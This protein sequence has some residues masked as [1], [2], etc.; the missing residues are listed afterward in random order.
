MKKGK[1]FLRVARESF[2]R[3]SLLRPDITGVKDMIL[4]L[5]IEMND[6]SAAELHARQVLRTNR[7]HALANYVMGSLRLQEGEYGEAEDFLRRSVEA[8]PSSAALNDL[9]EVLRRI[10]KLDDAERFARESIKRNPDLYV[11]WETLG[12][13]LLEANR[14]LEEAESAVNKALSLYKEDFRIKITLA[15]I[16]HRRGNLEKARETLS[17]VKMHKDGL[18]KFDLE[19]MNQL[20]A[21]I[22]KPRAK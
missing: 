19:V 18:T 10:R 2:I 11:A 14:N 13:V 1:N 5:D 15:R 12:C 4:Q 21:E 17:E 3:A 22:S 6:Q 20:S 8:N 7:K 16:Q 9:A